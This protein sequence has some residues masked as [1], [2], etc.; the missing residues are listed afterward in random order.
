MIAFL[1]RKYGEKQTTGHICFFDG[2]DLVFDCKTLEPPWKYNLKNESCI[3]ESTIDQPY[4]HVKKHISPTYGLCFKVF[5]VK[6]RSEILF[7]L[8]NYY[9]NTDGCILVGEAFGDI[10]KDGLKDVINSKDT[11]DKM[12]EKL[13]DSFKLYIKG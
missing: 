13:P 1:S 2:D 5:G 8:G 6:G 4:F 7:H 9:D 3:Y 12:M 10:N 11:F